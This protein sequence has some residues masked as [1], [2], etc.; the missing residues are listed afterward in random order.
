MYTYQQRFQS[1]L[2]RDNAQTIHS[3]NLHRIVCKS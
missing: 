1:Y 2:G 3:V